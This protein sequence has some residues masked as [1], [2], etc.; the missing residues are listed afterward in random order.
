MSKQPE[1]IQNKKS[2]KSQNPKNLENPKNS[3][4]G[5]PD[6]KRAQRTGLSARRAQR[7]KSRGP[8]GLQLDVGARRAPRLLVCNI[9]STSLQHQQVRERSR[10][11]QLWARLAGIMRRRS[12]IE[13]NWFWKQKLRMIISSL[14]SFFYRFSF[15][16]A[17]RSQFDII[18]KSPMYNFTK[19]ITTYTSRKQVP[20]SVLLQDQQY[21]NSICT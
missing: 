4:I 19:K 17:S 1:R 12:D 9:S 16:M 21:C 15:M 7:T 5:G 2:G 14:G 20:T 8:K 3:K 6:L 10:S 13:P 11:C 18:W